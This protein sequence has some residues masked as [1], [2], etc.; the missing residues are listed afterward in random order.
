MKI[1]QK[2][3]LIFAGITFGICI[4]LGVM[5]YFFFHYYTDTGFVSV[6]QDEPGKPFM[7][8][9]FGVFTVLFLFTSVISLISAFVFKDK[10]QK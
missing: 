7:S 8:Y 10:E 3:L 2:K 1:T 5:T 9:M 4:A 6:K